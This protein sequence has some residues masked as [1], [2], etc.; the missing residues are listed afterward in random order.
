MA[1]LD[2]HTWIERNAGFRVYPIYLYRFTEGW[3]VIK[4]DDRRLVGA[5]LLSIGGHSAE[6]VETQD[7]RARAL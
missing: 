7:S 1:L 2:T 6:E 5:K 4:A 3:F